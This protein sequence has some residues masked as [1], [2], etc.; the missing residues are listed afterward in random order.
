MSAHSLAKSAII[1]DFDGTLADSLLLGLERPPA[2]ETL[3]RLVVS[4]ES[5]VEEVVGRVKNTAQPRGDARHTLIVGERG[6]GKTT[7]LLH[8][9][10]LLPD[11]VL[12]AFVDLQEATQV[13]GLGGL[14][15]NWADAAVAAAEQH[16]PARVALGGRVLR[17]ALR[18]QRVRVGVEIEGR[19]REQSAPV[20]G[21]V[22]PPTHSIR[23]SSSSWRPSS[24][25]WPGTSPDARL[26]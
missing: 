18:G 3:E 16:E 7:F 12:P 6:M 8:L 24:R 21:G 13:S 10:R 25:A 2:P 15:Y 14:Y 17:D 1:F 23:S 9:P 26:K 22:S 20:G 4:R 11:E 5:M 19:Q